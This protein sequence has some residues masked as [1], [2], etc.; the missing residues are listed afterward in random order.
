[1]ATAQRHVAALGAAFP[2]MDKSQLQEARRRIANLETKWGPMLLPL[3][4]GLEIGGISPET[5]VA[6]WLSTRRTPERLLR[7][8][9]R[10][11]ERIADGETSLSNVSD[12][13]FAQETDHVLIP[14]G[15]DSFK[16]WLVELRI[17]KRV[18]TGIYKPG[19]LCGWWLAQMSPA[20]GKGSAYEAS[21]AAATQLRG[22]RRFVMPDPTAG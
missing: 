6:R 13:A 14:V 17:A 15:S 2:Y 22:K 7:V 5:R 9:Y 4:E 19:S 11:A 1:M 18:S 21:L 8:L 20:S 16:E 12:Y 3:T 10:A